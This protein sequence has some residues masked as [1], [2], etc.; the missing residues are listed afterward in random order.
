MRIVCWGTYDIGKPRVRIPLRGLKENNIEVIE[1]HKEVRGRIEDKSQIAGLGAK[2]RFAVKWLANYPSLILADMHLPK[3]DAVIVSYLE[4][5][6]AL[7]VMHRKGFEPFVAVSGN[8]SESSP[9]ILA[10]EFYRCKC[11]PEKL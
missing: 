4:L 8:V 5:F 3:H 1:C 9:E 7:D 10:G 6:C 11:T 2:L